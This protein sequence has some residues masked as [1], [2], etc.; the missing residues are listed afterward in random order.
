MQGIK[1]WMM[2][3]VIFVALTGVGLCADAPE[4]QE[5]APAEKA[6]SSPEAIFKAMEAKRIALGQRA[7]EIRLEEKKL[8]EF[9]V[10]LEAKREALEALRQQIETSLT[11]L[12]AKEKTVNEA[13]RLEAEKKILQL[14]KLYSSMKPKQAAAIINNM[15]VVMTERLFMRL[16]GDVAGKILAAVDP[17][18]AARISERLA[19]TLDDLPP[20]E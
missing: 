8:K 19:E 13:Q 7:E 3:I 11:R 6:A 1:Q 2:G 16:K 9:K 5:A 4:G 17:K 18:I 20:V 15:D 12:E 14:V 10:E